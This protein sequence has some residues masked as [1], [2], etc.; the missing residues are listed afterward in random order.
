MNGTDRVEAATFGGRNCGFCGEE[1]DERERKNDEDS[2]GRDELAG[3]RPAA[4]TVFVA[5]R[6]A[7]A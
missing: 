1:I 5:R 3:C 2:A 4:P 6:I 7:V